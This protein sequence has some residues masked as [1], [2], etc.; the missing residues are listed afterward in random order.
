MFRKPRPANTQQARFESFTGEE[1]LEK[2]GYPIGCIPRPG[3]KMEK[4]QERR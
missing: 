1:K 4:Y 2:Q 3:R